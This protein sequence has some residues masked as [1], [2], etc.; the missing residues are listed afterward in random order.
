MWIPYLAIAAVTLSIGALVFIVFTTIPVKADV[1]AA[2]APSSEDERKRVERNTFSETLATVMPSGYTGWV[3]R[4]II[5]AGRATSW[6]V[7]GFLIV[8]LIVSIV[9]VLIIIGAVALS[10]ELPPHHR[11][12]VRS[13]DLLRAGDHAQQSS[14]RSTDRHPART[15][16]HARPDDHRG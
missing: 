11:H 1:V 4:K 8:R 2:V 14:R 16:R 9:A 15:P 13:P 5:Y 10:A 6:T 7:G 12:R 3:Q